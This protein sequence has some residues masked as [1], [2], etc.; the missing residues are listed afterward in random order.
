ML[1]ISNVYG[2]G[3]DGRQ[4]SKLEGMGFRLRPQL[5]RYMG[6]QVCHFIDFEEGPCLEPIVVEDDQEYL[7][8]VPEGMKPYC[9]GIS[10]VLPEGTEATVGDY[11]REFRHLEP[12]NLHVN[13]DG[14]LEPGGPGW[15]YLNF[16]IPV[17]RDT[18][19]WLTALDE[20]RPVRKYERVHPNGVT[21]LLGLVFDL[22]MEALQGLAHLAKGAF[23]DGALRIGE[24][25]VWSRSAVEDFPALQPK[26]FP[27][28]AIVLKTKN[29]DYFTTRAEHAREVSFMSHRAF[30][31]ETNRLCWD[32]V[33]VG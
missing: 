32:I 8:F 2:H 19:I 33:V 18:F 11:E 21:G 17:V 6:S 13:Y 1:A 7:D 4:F 14:S 27:L 28:V 23:T 30:L 22:E 12:Y 24:L 31:I 25:K 10:L 29:L 16:K 9:P 3:F 20:P 26:A 5:S 15:N